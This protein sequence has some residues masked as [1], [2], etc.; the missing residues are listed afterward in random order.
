MI[1]YNLMLIIF[2]FVVSYANA[3]DNSKWNGCLDDQGRDVPGWCYDRREQD[4][5]HILRQSRAWDDDTDPHQGQG[6]E[7]NWDFDQDDEDDELVQRALALS[8]I[9][10]TQ[11]KEGE[12]TQEKEREKDGTKKKKSDRSSLTTAVP[13]GSMTCD[14]KIGER[15][16]LPD[17]FLKDIGQ[18][19]TD[20]ALALLAQDPSVVNVAGKAGMTMLYAACAY[21]RELLK[22][23]ATLV[24]MYKADINKPNQSGW[25]PLH[26]ACSRGHVKIVDFLLSKGAQQVRTIDGRTPLDVVMY[27]NNP[28]YPA[29]KILL[30]ADLQKCNQKGATIA[31]TD[32]VDEIRRQLETAVIQGNVQEFDRL[33]RE[34]CERRLINVAAVGV[35]GSIAEEY[36]QIGIIERLF[37]LQGELFPKDG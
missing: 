21:E 30:V 29:I 8:L 35:L 2:Y 14:S 25:T 4:S 34:N 22:F 23:V 36:G 16:H 24:E 1:F 5:R 32:N 37:S 31:A 17:G 13:L 6:Q 18:G 27:E 7:W 28:P 9:E 10:R 3:A 15:R 11:E 33:F 19:K 12:Q 26:R 20:S